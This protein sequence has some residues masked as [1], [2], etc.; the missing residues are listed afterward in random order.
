MSCVMSYKQS[1]LNLK[2][3]YM[4]YTSCEVKNPSGVSNAKWKA[5]GI[6]S[7]SVALV[8]P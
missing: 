6:P 2:Y 1:A 4:V 7:V 3:I 8:R 5:W